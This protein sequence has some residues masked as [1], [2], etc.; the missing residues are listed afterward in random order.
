MG[1]ITSLFAGAALFFAMMPC[2]AASQESAGLYEESI[3]LSVRGGHD[4]LGA[5]QQAV[6]IGHLYA[7]GAVVILSPTDTQKPL[8]EM[9]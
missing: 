8:K 4:A 2:T 7:R 5:F 6:S 3:P 1:E 9:E